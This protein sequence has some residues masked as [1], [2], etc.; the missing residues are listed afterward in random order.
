MKMWLCEK[1]HRSLHYYDVPKIWKKN[2]LSVHG[3]FQIWKNMLYCDYIL[4][5]EVVVQRLEKVNLWS[6]GHW[7][8]SL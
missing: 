5:G 7:I 2:S 1:Q 6:Q 3:Y 4:L 8:N